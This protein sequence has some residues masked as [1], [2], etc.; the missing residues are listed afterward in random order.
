MGTG[1]EIRPKPVEGVGGSIR[2]RKTHQIEV[3]DKTYFAR[4]DIWG[5]TPY[6]GILAMLLHIATQMVQI[7][8]LKLQL[9]AQKFS[10]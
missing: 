10:H 2:L 4:W 8:V 7:V 6:S 5:E 3:F 9:K 1:H